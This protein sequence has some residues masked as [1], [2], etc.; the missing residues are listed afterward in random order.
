MLFSA[1]LSFLAT[2]MRLKYIAFIVLLSLLANGAA[3]RDDIAPAPRKMPRTPV[4][5][6][7]LT[8]GKQAAPPSR[9]QTGQAVVLDS[10]RIKIGD[11]EMRL[12]GIVPPG[13]SASFGPQARSALDGLT[14]AGVT[15]CVIR[16]RSRDRRFLATC[17]AANGAD[18]ALE[19][20]KRGLAVTARGSLQPTDLAAPYAAAEQAAQAQRL[21]LWSVTVPVA[22]S[23]AAMREAKARGESAK[24]GDKKETGGEDQASRPQEKQAG[25]KE[26]QPLVIEAGT[27]SKKE[28]KQEAKQETKQEPATIPVTVSVSGKTDFSVPELADGAEPLSDSPPL[29]PWEE[30][31][32]APAI[33]EKGFF[34]RYQLLLT[35][36]LMLLTALGILAAVAVQRWLDHREEVRSIAAALRGELMAARALCLA[37]LN[38]T[39]DETPDKEISWPR[40]RALVFQAYVGRLGLLGSAL[41]R[42]VAS[43]YGQAS[44]FSAYYNNPSSAR[45]AKREPVSKRQSLQKLLRHIEEVLPKLVAVEQRGYAD[46]RFGLSGRRFSPAL[47][48]QI[49][50][51]AGDALAASETASASGSVKTAG[52]TG[53]SDT[54][55][56]IIETAKN[57]AAEK[58]SRA[59]SR[60][61]AQQ[62]VDYEI[63]SVEYESG[64]MH[65]GGAFDISDEMPQ[66]EE[67]KTAVPGEN[68]RAGE[69]GREYP[70]GKI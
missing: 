7:T 6:E 18:L 55:K 32:L 37:R 4:A 52:K 25:E 60:I 23:D 58:L 51:G 31:L 12:F 19:L 64:Q 67:E 9:I 10:E 65:F 47:S 36:V 56:R 68:Q 15:T 44:D 33:A 43:I 57:F 39:T 1:S 69:E 30:Y 70:A 53:I 41:S 20:L 22:V 46:G 5:R 35:G 2:Y 54:L 59:D 17:H 26:D 29:L 49:S 21:G 14:A 48:T 61:S 50:H 63:Y 3:A 28:T 11:V 66:E 42:Q 38:S 8:G 16:D 40:I 45:E 27:D 62:N 13:L 34:E 24:A